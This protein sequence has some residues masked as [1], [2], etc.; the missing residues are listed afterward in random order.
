[1][2]PDSITGHSAKEVSPADAWLHPH[3]VVLRPFVTLILARVSVALVMVAALAAF[4]AFSSGGPDRPDGTSAAGIGHGHS[5]LVSAGEAYRRRL[6]VVAYRQD[7]MAV[8][9]QITAMW[10][11][12]QKGLQTLARGTLSALAFLRP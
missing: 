6:V 8:G 10:E 5:R 4:P 2:E 11:V 3:A 9:I 1:M 7:V 12:C